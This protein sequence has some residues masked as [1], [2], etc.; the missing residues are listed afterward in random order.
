LLRYFGDLDFYVCI[1]LLLAALFVAW[2]RKRIL[3][4]LFFFTLFS[5]YLLIALT[6]V[7]F[8]F[9]IRT[10]ANDAPFRLTVNLIPFYFG[11]CQLLEICI[12]QALQNILLTIPFG[13][14]LRFV[15][16]FK[17]RSIFRLA[18]LAGLSTEGLQLLISLIFQ[19]G[20]RAIDINDSLL[21][22]LGVLIGYALFRI[23]AWGYLT[24]LKRFTIQPTGLFA[25]LC[26]VA[27]DRID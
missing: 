6:Q 16:S 2:Y 11:S 15:A 17:P 18:L 9:Y 27:T 20:F 26:S 1:T 22:A 8:P 21:N 4:Y 3:S 24:I 14:G 10:I 19:S 23:F 5:L 13:F 7:I 12:T 25:Y